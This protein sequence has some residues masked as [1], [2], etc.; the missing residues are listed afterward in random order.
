M[1]QIFEYKIIVFIVLGLFVCM[2]L[3]CCVRRFIIPSWRERIKIIR[4][5]PVT[6]P[7]IMVNP[8]RIKHE[9]IMRMI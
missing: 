7:T 5:T 1:H 9:K 6:E 4:I 8:M 2:I 3:F